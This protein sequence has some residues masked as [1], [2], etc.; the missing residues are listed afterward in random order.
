[1]IEAVNGH[2]VLTVLFETPLEGEALARCE[3]ELALIFKA[4]LPGLAGDSVPTNP[5]T[6]PS[7]AP[8]RL[9]FLLVWE[10]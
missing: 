10:S 6:F 5:P 2:D 3:E 7:Q 8:P 9:S 1:M 4:K